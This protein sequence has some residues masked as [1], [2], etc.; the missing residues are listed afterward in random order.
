MAD[1]RPAVH[2][3]DASADAILAALARTLDGIAATFGATTELVL[4]DYRTPA[5]SV[6]AI[7]GSVTAR[8][9][10]GALSEIG[11][12]MLSHGDTAEDKLNYVT[13]TANGRMIKS[14]TMALR[15]P[16][17]RMFGALCVNIDITELKHTINSLNSLIG[18]T[19]LATVATTVFSDDIGEVI[20]TV[21]SQEEDRLGRT[22]R[23]DHRQGRLEVIKALDSRGVF[24][25]PQ[26][27]NEVAE[28]VGVSRATVYADLNTVRGFPAPAA[29]PE[30]ATQKPGAT[31]SRDDGDPPAAGTTA[32][33]PTRG[34]RRGRKA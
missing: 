23:H 16:A 19:V 8:H 12:D 3:D 18:E 30:A 4:H 1:Q 27:A 14:S 24:T 28:H 29:V 2:A 15:D 32:R 26:A 31:G 13:R 10:G 34:P 7:A 20:R 25:L 5:A 33:R 22:L 17:G 9:V 11:L 21:I 6:V